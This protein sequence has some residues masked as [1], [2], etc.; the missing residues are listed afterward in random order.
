[1]NGE[2]FYRGAPLDIA[3][4]GT[5]S[6]SA[7]DARAALGVSS[8]ATAAM[9]GA[10]AVSAILATSSNTHYERHP[11]VPSVVRLAP[12]TWATALDAIAVPPAGWTLSNSANLDAAS[13]A[14][15]V[16]TMQHD[17]SDDAYGGGTDTCPTLR[18][19]FTPPIG[20]LQI[21]GRIQI[22][23][24]LSTNDT[25]GTYFGY[26]SGRATL[27]L[28]FTMTS[29]TVGSLRV[30]DDDAV[31]ATPLASQDEATAAVG[32]CYRIT[33]D[34]S[35]GF[36]LVEYATGAAT[37]PTSWTQVWRNQSANFISGNVGPWNIA[38][39]VSRDNGASPT[40]AYTM[41]AE[42]LWS[43]GIPAYTPF[44]GRGMA[45]TG[46]TIKLI[47]SANFGAAVTPTIATL[48]TMLAD[49]INR[50]PGD[51]AT[52]TFGITGSSSANP[53]APTTLQ[54]A[55]AVVL[56]NAGTDTAASSAYQYWAIHASAASASGTQSGSIDTSLIKL[57]PV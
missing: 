46:D 34:T 31:A 16:L 8:A 47:A 55:A 19:T 11:D 53:A 49:A 48:R 12:L 25:V 6:T 7:A 52:W 45:T 39:R 4:G 51:A 27:G 44:L 17:N 22:S 24:D 32:W 2:G 37:E 57:A 21:T 54:S 29:S 20:R 43:N 35:S 30:I 10:D 38:H 14:S 33:F 28:D 56:K 41:F 36:Y 1:M 9:V 13:V 26:A 23:G 18:R 50:L 5:G 40:G 15:G 3:S 42:R